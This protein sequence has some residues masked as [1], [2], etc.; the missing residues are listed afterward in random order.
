MQPNLDAGAAW[1]GARDLSERKRLGQW[2][3]PW[4]LCALGAAEALEGVPPGARVLDLGCGDGRWLLA[5][6]LT[7]PDLVLC[8]LDVDPAA[9][10]A[11]R[12]TL[13]EAGL[14]ADLRV[15]DALAADAPFPEADVVLGNPPYIR[16]QRLPPATRRDLWSRYEAATDKAD[17]YA[18][19][20]ERA[21]RTAPRV[22][23]ILP[24]TWMHMQSYAALRGLVRPR[25]QAVWG[26][27]P[28]LFP[29]AR[30]FSAA[31]HLAPEA[32][33]A[34]MGGQLAPDGLSGVGPLAFGAHAWSFQGALPELPGR[35]LSEFVHIHMGVLCGD[36]ERFVH[37]GRRGA[38]DRPTCRGR[39]VG[40]GQIARPDLW[41][42]YEPAEMLAARSYVAPKHAGIFDVD[43]KI[44]LS[45]TSGRRLR[46]AL[47]RQRLFPLDSCY[48][49]LPRSPGMDLAAILGFLLSE[50]VGAWYAARHPAARV[51]GVEVARIP[52]P[53][54]G[55]G[56]VADAAR[57]ERW[58]RLD[59]AVRTAYAAEASA[60][61]TES[62]EADHGVTEGH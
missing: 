54:K 25:V 17:I 60:A 41:I 27:A 11:A 48:V 12:R 49:L 4:W 9:I 6:G 2:V 16:P 3:T 21:L 31:L 33:V 37:E 44:V 47:D 26:L 46:A 38:S 18:C 39:D 30:V 58:D 5:A 10:E 45:G 43:E 1:L 23:L 14:S 42:R 56:P 52:I 61:V 22:F 55:W 40:V 24:D 7:R 34:P 19:F 13:A 59:A 28:G 53:S 35:P 32:P 57:A 51:K 29:G 50:P 36:Q 8:G 20:V 62:E 15:A